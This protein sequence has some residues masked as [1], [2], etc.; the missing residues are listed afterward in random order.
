MPTSKYPNGF[1]NGVAIL[2]MPVLNLYGSSS[3]TDDLTIIQDTTALVIKEN[4]NRFSSFNGG[5]S[6]C[7][8]C[9]LTLDPNAHR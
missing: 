2:G 4:S 6:N 9:P 5:S 3:M 1:N 7:W 8:R